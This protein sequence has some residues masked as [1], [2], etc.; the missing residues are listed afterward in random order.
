VSRTFKPI[1]FLLLVWAVTATALL[2]FRPEL[3][4]SINNWIFQRES[5]EGRLFLTNDNGPEGFVAFGNETYVFC[6]RPCSVEEFGLDGARNIWMCDS[7][8]DGRRHLCTARFWPGRS[9]IVQAL[10]LKTA[11]D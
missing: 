6:R 1:L 11:A 7:Q 3:S 9:Y 10:R 5:A 8:W 4:M 2:C